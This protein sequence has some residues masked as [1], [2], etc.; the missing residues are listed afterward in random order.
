[1]EAVQW[2]PNSEACCITSRRRDNERG[3]D[4]DEE[5]YFNEDDDHETVAIRT[6]QG[7]SQGP[8]SRPSTL[9]PAM[10][11]G[12]KAGAKDEAE[13]PSSASR[14]HVIA[15]ENGTVTVMTASP[16]G[17]R[18]LFSLVDYDDDDEEQEQGDDDDEKQQQPQETSAQQQ[19]VIAYF[20]FSSLHPLFLCVTPMLSCVPLPPW[21]TSRQPM[22]WML[23]LTCTAPVS[24]PGH[25]PG[26]HQ[27]CKH[28][29]AAGCQPKAS[30]R[31]RGGGPHPKAAAQWWGG[32][33]GG[34]DSSPCDFS[35]CLCRGRVFQ[36][37]LASPSQVALLVLWPSFRLESTRILKN[38]WDR[39]GCC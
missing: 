26:Q 39:P 1:M 22:I 12:R 34:A 38:L 16:S 6:A 10:V 19:M 17:A 7:P 25:Q 14:P 15:T 32:R 9:V 35:L 28:R 33:G 29:G 13:V 8:S 31:W 2:P 3:L 30:S 11:A 36:P 4:K 27:G 21:V 20:S 5:D 18:P 23:S 37:F 24:S